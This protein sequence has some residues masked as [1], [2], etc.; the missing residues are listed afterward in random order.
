MEGEIAT[1][2]KRLQSLGAASVRGRL[3]NLGAYPGAVADDLSTNQIHGELFELPADESILLTLDN[4]EDFD[5][6]KP[7]DCLFV[8]RRASAELT[9]GRTMEAWIYTYNRDPED[10]PLIEGGK[11]SKPPNADYKSS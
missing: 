2:I 9:D 5:P 3:Y 7:G 8:R 4:Y 6:Q 1:V 10:A 11:W